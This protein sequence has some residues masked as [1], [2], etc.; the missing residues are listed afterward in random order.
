MKNFNVSSTTLLLLRHTSSSSTVRRLQVLM[1]DLPSPIFA[2]GL[3]RN[4]ARERRKDPKVKRDSL[5]FQNQPPN[6]ISKRSSLL[7]LQLAHRR[8]GYT[9]SDCAPY[10]N[11][12]T[13]TY[14]FIAA[15]GTNPVLN[16]T[17]A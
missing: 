11:T 14:T 16:A 1:F 15:G 10:T 4:L 12:E 6:Q 2:Y 9:H 5:G 13:V 7:L 17:T 8:A 3:A